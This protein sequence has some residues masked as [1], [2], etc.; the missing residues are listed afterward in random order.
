MS[1]ELRE[2]I[3]KNKV[4]AIAYLL[5]RPPYISAVSLNARNYKDALEIALCICGEKA[6]TSLVIVG[7][8]SELFK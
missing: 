5:E 1:E 4:Y 2:D 6:A 3:P 8:N 7:K